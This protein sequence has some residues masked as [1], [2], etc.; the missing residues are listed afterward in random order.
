L[1]KGSNDSSYFVN[2]SVHEVKLTVPA[3]EFPRIQLVYVSQGRQTTPE[4]LDS[5]GFLVPAPTPKLTLVNSTPR[6]RNILA[7]KPFYQDY[8]NRAP[9]KEDG[10]P[11]LNSAD[12]SFVIRLRALGYSRAEAAAELRA[13]RD[14]AAR[15]LDYVERTLNAA[16]DWLARNPAPGRERVAI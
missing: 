15:R 5:A 9:L 10:K 16:D 4:E 1:T 6:P 13:V 14:K 2:S 7:P 11:N 8:V 3:P 12:E